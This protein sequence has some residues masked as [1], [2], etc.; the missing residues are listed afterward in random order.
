[1]MMA[2]ESVLCDDFTNEFDIEPEL[3]KPRLAPHWTTQEPEHR[4]V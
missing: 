2:D 3:L 1:M 4:L